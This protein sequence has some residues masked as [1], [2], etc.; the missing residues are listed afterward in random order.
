MNAN[1]ESFLKLIKSI[2][3]QRDLMIDE[4]NYNFNIFKVIGM[5][6]DEVKLHSTFLAELFNP[7]GSHGMGD[8]FL[9]EFLNKCS[10]IDGAFDESKVEVEIE[11]YIGEIPENKKTGGRLDIFITDRAQTI[12]I[13]NKIYAPDQEKQLVRY[14]NY[15]ANAHIIYLT[16][17]G[18]SPTDNSIC[19][20]EENSHYHCMSY[21]KD[22]VEWLER[23]LTIVREKPL[24]YNTLLQYINTIKELTN[25]SLIPTMDRVLSAAIKNNIEASIEIEKIMPKIRN[26]FHREFWELLVNS[27]GV[28]PLKSISNP[29]GWSNYD[30]IICYEIDSQ[31]KGETLVF[32]IRI[33]NNSGIYMGITTKNESICKDA[34]FGPIIA[35]FPNWESMNGS[36]HIVWKSIGLNFWKCD[37]RT[38]SYMQSN[39]KERENLVSNLAV[40]IKE[41]KDQLTDLCVKS[42]DVQG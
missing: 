3:H 2:C 33:S 8:L 25:Q 23:C 37:P 24:F 13:E 26:E 15:N 12:I 18:H 4:K 19:D 17:D 35:E 38:I 5:Q 29:Q 30:E 11:K 36:A 22:V 7:K 20:L 40:E 42:Q 1:T 16:L 27:L 41:I 34:K 21:A 39:E 9:V 32:R 14:H 28:T 10:F 31:Y 6:A